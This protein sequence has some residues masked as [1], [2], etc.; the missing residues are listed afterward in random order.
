MSPSRRRLNCVAPISSLLCSSSSSVSSGKAASQREI[1]S[2]FG[3]GGTS[4]VSSPTRGGGGRRE[5]PERR[6]ARSLRHPL[7]RIG[8]HAAMRL[9]KWR[10]GGTKR[11]DPRAAGPTPRSRL[12]AAAANPLISP[13]SR[14]DGRSAHVSRTDGEESPGSRKHGAG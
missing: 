9:S 13:V 12:D 6:G 2:W 3:I 4:L 11:A 14:P 5:D 1:R 10:Y 7:P 8:E